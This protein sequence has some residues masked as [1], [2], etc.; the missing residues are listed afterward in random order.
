M[1]TYQNLSSAYFSVQGVIHDGFL[2]NLTF[3]EFKI[4]ITVGI[5]LFPPVFDISHKFWIHRMCR[6][7]DEIDFSLGIRGVTGP[8][9]LLRCCLGPIGT[10]FVQFATTFHVRFTQTTGTQLGGGTAK[11]KCN[12]LASLRISSLLTNNLLGRQQRRR[13]ADAIVVWA[14]RW[15]EGI[16]LGKY[17]QKE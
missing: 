5:N 9:Y 14:R 3:R 1:I 6:L 13:D 10:S 17:K 4:I 12:G 2:D 15:L 7:D 11:T 16:R 8:D